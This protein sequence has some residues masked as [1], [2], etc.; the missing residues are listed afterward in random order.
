[1]GQISVENFSQPGSDL[2]G[3]QHAAASETI[4]AKFC[5]A[6]S[7]RNNAVIRDVRCRP[8]PIWHH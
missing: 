5:L 4:A 6:F 2:N 3:N 8:D 1:M 7:H